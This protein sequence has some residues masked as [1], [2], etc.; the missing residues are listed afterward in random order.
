VLGHDNVG[1]GA[2]R[3]LVLNDWIADT[4]TWDSARC[5]LDQRSFSW[6]FADL[7]GYGR[8]RA[9]PGRYT[10]DEATQD[11]LDLASELGWRRF[12]I[13]G[14]SMS[15]LIA[16]QLAQQHAEHIER[17]IVLTPPPPAGFGVDDSTFAAMR[18]AAADVEHRGAILKRMWGER[19][20]ERWLQ[21]KLERWNASSDAE[22]VVAYIAMWAQRGLPDPSTPIRVPVL[23]ITGEQDNTVMQR[24]SVTKLLS[25][26]CPSL[27]IAALTDCGHYP[28]QEAPPLLVTLVERFAGQG[29]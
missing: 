22:A 12:T 17:A 3:I 23:A 15:A 20:S 5:Y 24:A 25:P 27:Q 2:R 16:L 7:R 21:F 29:A 26:L 4:S 13:V 1:F 11:A 9:M 19:L 28:M 14:H 10:L 6:A 18:A 8:S